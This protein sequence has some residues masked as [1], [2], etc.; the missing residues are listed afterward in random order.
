MS[1]KTAFISDFDGTIT[2]EDFFW[3][4]AARWLDAEALEPW[5]EYLAGKESHLNALNRI[6]SCIRVPK[7]ELDAFIKTIPY[8]KDFEKTAVY[9]RQKDIPFY[10]CSAG[11]DYY[12]NELIGGII[13]KENIQLVTNHG[14]YSPE[15]GLEMIPPPQSSPY[16]DEKIGISK[17]AIVRKLKAEGYKVVFAGDGPPDIAPARLADVVFAKKILLEKCREEGIKTETF[18]DYNDIFRYLKEV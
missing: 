16:Y 11:C 1:M 14:V 18:N 9:C 10:I 6:F 2:A 15:S 12:I 3:Y 4:I 5:Q 13:K 7:T 8:D 17:A